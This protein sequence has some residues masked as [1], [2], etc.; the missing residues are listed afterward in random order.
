MKKLFYILCC[1]L[2][3]LF[4]ACEKG[5]PSEKSN[6]D[7]SSS[8][9]GVSK[10]HAYVDLGLSVKWA[11]CNVGATKPEDYG[12]YFAWGETAPKE[13][14]N[15]SNYK[16][17]NMNQDD[18]IIKY[19]DESDYGTVDNKTILE[20]SDDA[21]NANWGGDW[22]MPTY[23]EQYELQTECIWTW[24][25]HGVNGYKVTSKINGN[26]IFLPAAG[27]DDDRKGSR[28]HYW[29]TS[30]GTSYASFYACTMN[31]GSDYI[32]LGGA[33]RY[34]GLPIRPVLP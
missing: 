10:G 17:F 23:A 8:G 11:T 5:E 34:I 22:R 4:T 18:Y 15:R 13:E 33:I 29:N 14:Y 3:V 24:T 1:S 27:S 31:F 6:G 12:D 2:V 26:S 20:F 21:A 30:L 19:C 25:K 7:G 28:G 9:S 32:R 16:W